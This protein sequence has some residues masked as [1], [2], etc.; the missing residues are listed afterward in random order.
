MLQTPS[1]RKENLAALSL[2]H[3]HTHGGVRSPF[4]I[5]IS[6]S[7]THTVSLSLSVFFTRTSC[8]L[9]PASAEVSAFCFV[10]GGCPERDRLS[11]AEQVMRS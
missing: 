5:Y 6:L 1:H 2:T 10:F 11:L 7:L 8:T 4:D 9:Q 3:T